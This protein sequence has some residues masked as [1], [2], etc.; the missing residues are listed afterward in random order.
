MTLRMPGSGCSWPCAGCA[1]TFQPTLTVAAASPGSAF[2]LLQELEVE[3][4]AAMAGRKWPLAIAKLREGL[5]LAGDLAAAGETELGSA[6]LTAFG[7][8]L[9]EAYRRGDA[10]QESFDV[11]VMALE[12]APEAELSRALLLE[13]LG[14]SALALGRHGDAI[15]AWLDAAEVA[16]VAGNAAVEK[17]LLGRIEGDTR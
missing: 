6:A 10:A 11:L 17:R 5:R 8:K 16:R 15:G 9:G 4:A 12:R 3:A 1:M 7:R 13:E 14:L 2:W